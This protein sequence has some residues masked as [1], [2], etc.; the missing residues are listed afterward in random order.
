LYI[1]AAN[2]SAEF[3]YLIAG[4]SKGEL[5]PFEGIILYE[6]VKKIIIFL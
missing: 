2:S 3:L 5:L 1:N 6:P 4:F